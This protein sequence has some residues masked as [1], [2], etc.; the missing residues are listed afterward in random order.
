MTLRVL[1]GTPGDGRLEAVARLLL[2]RVATGRADSVAMITASEVTRRRALD[3]LHR[4]SGAQG[5]FDAPIFTLASFVERLH[6]TRPVPG[7]RL[8][9]AE[10]EVLLAELARHQPA[11][12]RELLLATPGTIRAAA[13]FITRLKRLGIYQSAQARASI[14]ALAQR[15]PL[16]LALLALLD[17]PAGAGA[18]RS[19]RRRGIFIEADPHRR[20]E[21][22]LDAVVPRP[23]LLLVSPLPRTA[24]IERAV[25]A[26][27]FELFQETVVTLDHWPSSAPDTPLGCLD[28]E[29]DR[30]G[31]AAGMLRTVEGDAEGGGRAVRAEA[32]KPRARDRGHRL[33]DRDAAGARNGSDRGPGR[34]PLP[35]VDRG[36]PAAPWALGVRAERVFAGAESDVRAGCRFARPPAI[37]PGAG[38]GRGAFHEPA[39]GGPVG[40]PDGERLAHELFALL[41][42]A[43]IPPR[44]ACPLEEWRARIAR[45]RAHIAIELASMPQNESGARQRVGQLLDEQGE[46]LLGVPSPSCRIP[47]ASCPLPVWWSSSPPARDPE[48]EQALP[49]DRGEHERAALERLGVGLSAVLDGMRSYQRAST[50]A[51]ATPRPVREHAALLCSLLERSRCRSRRPL[52]AV[53]VLAAR[54][55][56]GAAFDHVFVP[57]LTEDAFPVAPSATCS[58]AR[59]MPLR[60]SSRRPGSDCARLT[61]SWRRWWARPERA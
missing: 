1:E 24:A 50:S 52:A 13:R 18:V 32:G 27:L 45:S 4:Q 23:E 30:A 57:G 53:T 17:R 36:D 7:T 49:A 51:H 38:A 29:R 12:A 9:S 48:P 58:W 20:A 43:R 15:T 41:R 33:H 22:Q 60:S 28:G 26:R 46:R 56:A 2:E 37:R 61:I 44:A 5:F 11:G 16:L 42:G 10:K 59:P 6:L 25:L 55:I 34:G 47:T 19:V 21:L 8:S 54:D 39:G 3:R 35:A 14:P 31:R 40:R